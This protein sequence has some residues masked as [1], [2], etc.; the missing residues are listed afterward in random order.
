MLVVGL[1]SDTHGTL[2]KEA[3]RALRDADEILHAGDI[4]GQ[5]VADRLQRIA[6]TEVVAGNM[7]P[8]GSWP[9]E[10]VLTI[11]GRRVVLVHD[12]GHIGSPSY[13]FL[14]RAHAFEADMVV[15][16]HSHRPADFTVEGIRFVNP[17][18]AGPSRGGPPTIARMTMTDDGLEIVHVKVG[19]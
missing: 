8:P 16:G 13:D 4:G 19:S 18:S 14:Q 2:R 10:K 12:I 17:G 7:D 5:D 9:Y 3:I 1:I 15:F 6:P 11:V